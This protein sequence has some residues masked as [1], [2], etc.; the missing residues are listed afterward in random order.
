MSKPTRT[1]NVHETTGFL[2]KD[3]DAFLKQGFTSASGSTPTAGTAPQQ[4]VIKR[5]TSEIRSS[6]RG[7]FGEG[8]TRTS[9][10]TEQLINPNKVANLSQNQLDAFVN[11][12][13]TRRSNIQQRRAQPGRSQTSFNL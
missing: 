8:I 7:A 3:V 9:G 2:Q 6:A 13:S 1:T 12:F 11:A 10:S 4:Q 5:Q